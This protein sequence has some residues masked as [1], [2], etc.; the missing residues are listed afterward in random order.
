MANK[1]LVLLGLANEGEVV[2]KSHR[3]A[4]QADYLK[5]IQSLVVP[6]EGDAPE[7]KNSEDAAPKEKPQQPAEAKAEPTPAPRT[8]KPERAGTDEPKSGSFM[9]TMRRLAE[10]IRRPDDSAIILVRHDIEGMLNDIEEALLEG[11]VLLVDF[12]REPERDARRTAER[13]ITFVRLKKG[14]S[15]PLTDT[16]LLISMKNDAV[17]EWL[18]EPEGA[19]AQ[20]E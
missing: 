19:E 10:P 16:S 5:K 20:D 7:E 11:R 15:Y 18:P 6:E 1:F 13:L 8:E 14:Y 2:V 3:K 9:N 17:V 12:A 4:R